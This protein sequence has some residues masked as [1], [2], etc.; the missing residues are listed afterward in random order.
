MNKISFS[1]PPHLVDYYYWM[2]V[3]KYNKTE[4]KEAYFLFSISELYRV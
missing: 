3:N 2:Q 1:L 4:N